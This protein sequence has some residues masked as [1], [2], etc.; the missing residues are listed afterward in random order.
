[1]KAILIETNSF[2]VPSILAFVVS[3]LFVAIIQELCSIFPKR[4]R[5]EKN[6]FFLMGSVTEIFFTIRNEIKF[7][8]MSNNNKKLLL[9]SQEGLGKV[10]HSTVSDLKFQSNPSCNIDPT[11]IKDVLSVIKGNVSS[12]TS[13]DFGISRNMGD[14][15][16]HSREQSN[17]QFENMIDDR[18]NTNS[19]DL[20]QK[21]HLVQTSSSFEKKKIDKNGLVLIPTTALFIAIL[22]LL[23]I[24]SQA[25]LNIVVGKWTKIINIPQYESL[26]TIYD[27]RF[28]DSCNDFHCG[29]RILTSAFYTKDISEIPEVY[30]PPSTLGQLNLTY[31]LI[32]LYDKY[33]DNDPKDP[34]L[35]NDLMNYN[36]YF[37]DM[38]FTLT[39]ITT[40]LSADT[41][42]S[43][44]SN[45]R[46]QTA[47]RIE[48]LPAASVL[49][50]L[51]IAANNNTHGYATPFAVS[52]AYSSVNS[53]FG[54]GLEYSLKGLFTMEN[55]SYL[56]NSST[57]VLEPNN[58]S[59]SYAFFSSTSSST[60]YSVYQKILDY[61]NN[62]KYRNAHDT[63]FNSSSDNNT[64]SIFLN[65]SNYSLTSV[66]FANVSTERFTPTPIVI[67]NHFY[68]YEIKTN[69]TQTSVIPEELK[70]NSSS[71]MKYANHN[72]F[73]SDLDP[74]T[75]FITVSSVDLSMQEWI[76]TLLTRY[77]W[78][79]QNSTY[80][81]AGKYQT[82]VKANTDITLAIILTAV[83][84]GIYLILLILP[85]IFSL[86]NDVKTNVLYNCLREVATRRQGTVSAVPLSETEGVGEFGLVKTSNPMILGVS[87]GSKGKDDPTDINNDGFIKN[88]RGSVV[89]LRDNENL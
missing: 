78:F 88:Y 16:V 31:E 89:A 83:L 59:D 66:T 64:V 60:G 87:Q 61:A 26:K 36:Y 79:L 74:Q 58:W 47:Q 70:T 51:R 22:A 81:A 19:N 12:N 85:F 84:V 62:T 37:E 67:I 28:A 24:G 44:Y 21:E 29:S 77:P 76:N 57:E 25:V 10:S 46:N 33:G 23:F 72:G 3:A 39:M 53:V 20:E 45:L 54:F 49:Y 8:S 38:N 34:I 32:N 11:N 42:N 56:F 18:S 2:I 41:S 1:M 27:E 5:V 52:S 43:V 68:W 71:I 55:C 40:N 86:N 65:Q 50:S 80:D 75:I 9:N 6:L 4:F 15:K 14:V 30:T 69:T 82:D 48:L 35:L 13:I 17:S 63:F 7:K 73:I